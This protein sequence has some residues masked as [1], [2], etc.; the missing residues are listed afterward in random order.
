MKGG[1][2]DWI[3]AATHLL[4]RA[5]AAGWARYYIGS[6]PF[7]AMVLFYWSDMSHNAYTWRELT[8][9]SFAAAIAYLWMKC[10]QAA[11]ASELRFTLEGGDPKPWPASRIGRMVLFQTAVQPSGLFV[12]PMGM[13][14]AFPF[15]KIM[16]FYQGFSMLGDGEAGSDLRSV[17]SRTIKLSGLWTRQNWS[18]LS[19]LVAFGLF[20]FVNLAV[21]LAF[22]PE[23][24]RMYLGVD[25]AFTR[26]GTNVIGST[27][28]AVCFGLTYL[29]LDP[30]LKALAA[31]RCFHGEAIHSGA[32]LRAEVR[33]EPEVPLAHQRRRIAGRG[34]QRRHGRMRRGQAEHGIPAHARGHGFVGAAAQPILPAAGDQREARRRA[35]RGIGVAVGEPQAFGRH[36]VEARRAGVAFRRRAPAVAAEVRITEIV[37]ED[38][39]KVGF[40]AG[41]I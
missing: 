11:F 33:R 7:V 23:L 21:M 2:L 1:G 25:S 18:S 32:D 5:S 37:G 27:F 39:N 24:A 38:E 36:A 3:E 16:A 13:L 4:R 31:L 41:I 28:F 34:Q 35:H 20:V 12:I 22:I 8:G 26:A 14:V 15:A 29:T 17:V 19:I 40:H 30:L 10:W 9:E 6:L